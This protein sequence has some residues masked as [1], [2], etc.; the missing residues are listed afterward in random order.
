MIIPTTTAIT[1]PTASLDD[2][3]LTAIATAMNGGGLLVAR[4]HHHTET[5]AVPVCYGCTSAPSR[6]RPL[7]G[8]SKGAWV[9]ISFGAVFSLFLLWLAIRWLS[10]IVGHRRAQRREALAGTELLNTTPLPPTGGWQPPAYPPPT[11]PAPVDSPFKVNRVA[12]THGWTSETCKANG[13]SM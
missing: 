12:L 6:H 2:A 8:L 9:G 5:V 3:A 11:Y 1:F 7:L 10:N 4:K 13:E